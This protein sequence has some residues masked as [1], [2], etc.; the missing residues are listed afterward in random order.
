MEHA[1]Q[2]CRGSEGKETASAAKV[3]SLK[4]FTSVAKANPDEIDFRARLE[5]VL[6]PDTATVEPH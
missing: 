2:A 4:R 6:H 1:F 5:S 3:T